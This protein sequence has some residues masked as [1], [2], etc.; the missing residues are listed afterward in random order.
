MSLVYFGLLK[1]DSDYR[2]VKQKLQILLIDFVELKI[3]SK[4]KLSKNRRS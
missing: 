1:F 3:L 4:E 2:R